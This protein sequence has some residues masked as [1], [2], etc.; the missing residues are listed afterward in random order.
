[1]QC[2]ER[3]Y[4]LI[5]QRRSI[6]VIV[7][8]EVLVRPQLQHGIRML[9]SVGINLLTRYLNERI[10]VGELRPHDAEV[11][12]RMLIGSILALQLTAAPSESYLPGIIDI[13]LSGIEAN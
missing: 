7:A 10:A 3:A 8:R 2:A 5:S 11:T 12:A 9:Q 6:L 13:L 1:M 4:G